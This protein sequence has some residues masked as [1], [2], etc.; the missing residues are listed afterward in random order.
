V[1]RIRSVA[2]RGNFQIHDVTAYEVSQG[3]NVNLDLEVD[4]SLSLAAAH[5]KAT[6][7]ETE[8]KLELPEVGEVNV[9]IE[10]LPKRVETGGDA[11]LSQPVVEREL[12]E[13]A[14]KTPGVLDCHSVEAHQVGDAVM[15]SLHCTL[16]SHLP[17]ERVHDLTEDL[18][19]RFRKAFPQISKVSIHAEPEERH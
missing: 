3:V 7:L 10:P 5:D 14:Q 16:E 17:V 1:E 11:A 4:P 8:I 12:L 6:A 2:H 15:V 18:K 9:H 13:I 19:F